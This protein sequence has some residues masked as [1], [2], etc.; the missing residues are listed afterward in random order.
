[1]QELPHKMKLELAMQIHKRMYETIFFFKN[2]EKSFIAWIGTVLRPTN[3][4]EQEYI[5]K[6]GEEISESKKIFN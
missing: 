3:V 6:E 4:Q 5:Y 2:K 1:M